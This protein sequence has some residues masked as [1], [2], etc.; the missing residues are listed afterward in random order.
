MNKHAILVIALLVIL[1]LTIFSGY[2]ITNAKNENNSVQRKEELE[3]SN[4]SAGIDTSTESD[5]DIDNKLVQNV[6]IRALATGKYD[7]PEVRVK[8]N[9]PVVIH[10][11]ADK[12]SGCGK[13]FQLEDFNVKLFSYNGETTRAKILPKEKG[14]YYYHCGMWMFVGKL[15]VE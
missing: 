15:I 3:K 1:I 8:A 7:K 5:T 11:S 9:I 4:L 14:I 6:Y 10:F 13:A 2:L 12:D